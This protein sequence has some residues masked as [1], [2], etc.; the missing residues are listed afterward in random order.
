MVFADVTEAASNHD[1]FVVAAHTT[2]YLSFKCAEVARKIRPPKF[3]IERRR[4]NRTL[5]HDLQW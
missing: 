3:V 5:G 4:T 1:G 2:I